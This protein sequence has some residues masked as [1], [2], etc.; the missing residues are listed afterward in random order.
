MNGVKESRAPTGPSREE[1][2]ICLSFNP[3]S[4]L[5]PKESEIG[6]DRKR[7]RERE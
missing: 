5:Q 2:V 4:G 6:K 3:P 7:K 1:S